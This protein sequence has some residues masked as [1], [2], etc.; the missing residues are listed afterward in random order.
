LLPAAKAPAVEAP[1]APAA[2]VPAVEAPAAPAAK[3]PAAKVPAAKV[4]AAKVRAA[5]VLADNHE[6]RRGHGNDQSERTLAV[7]APARSQAEVAEESQ[8]ASTSTSKSLIQKRK[9]DCMEVS[10]EED[11]ESDDDDKS[12]TKGTLNSTQMLLFNKGKKLREILL[13]SND[14]HLE[15][16]KT[17]ELFSAM[18]E[19]S[20]VETIKV[21]DEKSAQD[22]INQWKKQETYCEKLLVAA[23]SFNLLH[24]ASLV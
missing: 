20:K 16:S 18:A 3:V 9:I 23:E 10:S 21:V 6:N 1:A 11:D 8:A 14:E 22:R 15:P 17:S 5:K 12:I 4:P 7:K 2:K 13:T 19:L 24:L